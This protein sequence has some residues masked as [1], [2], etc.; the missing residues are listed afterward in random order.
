MPLLVDPS[1][2]TEPGPIESL[3]AA[4]VENLNLYTDKYE[5]EFQPH[6]QMFTQAVWALLMKVGSEPKFDAL[7][8]LVCFVLRERH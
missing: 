5:E 6:L 3:Q 7:A 4:I 1:E 2:D 8:P